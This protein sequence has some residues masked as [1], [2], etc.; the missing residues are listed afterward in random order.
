MYLLICSQDIRQ[1]TLALYDGKNIVQSKVFFVA[2]EEHLQC[3]DAVL[4]EWNV[5]MA[6]MQGIVVVTGPGSFTASRVSVTLANAIALAQQIPV[7]GVANVDEMTLDEL[8]GT[9]SFECS[10]TEAFVHPFYNRP[11]MVT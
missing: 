6:D 10:P 5:V 3:L 8:V 9:V 1:V 7:W 2:P 4:S 11:A